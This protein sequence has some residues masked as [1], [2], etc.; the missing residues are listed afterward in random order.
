MTVSPP[1]FYA[2]AETVERTRTA[3]RVRLD[4][5]PGRELSW[6][7]GSPDGRNER[8]GRT[9][10]SVVTVEASGTDRLDLEARFRGG[11]REASWYRLALDSG[12]VPAS[13][14]VDLASSE[15][16]S[17]RVAGGERIDMRSEEG[18]ML[19]EVF[20]LGEFTQAGPREVF[21]LLNGLRDQPMSVGV[22]NVG[23]GNAN[24]LC[25]GGNVP[26]VYFDLG[27]GCAWNAAT[28][29]SRKAFC[30]TYDP[31]V[32]L[33]HWDFDHYF[34][35]TFLG[36]AWA[37]TWLVP[38]TPTVGPTPRAM[39]AKIVL[40]G[41]KVN[42][43]SHGPWSTTCGRVTLERP[44]PGSTSKNHSG[45]VMRVD[46]PGTTSARPWPVLLSGDMGYDYLPTSL[47]HDLGA[48]VAAHHG[49]SRYL[50]TPPPASQGP[51]VAYSFGSGNTYGHPK[52]EALDRHTA[53]GWH[54]RLDTMNGDIILAPQPSLRPVGCGGAQCGLFPVQ[55]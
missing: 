44:A 26:L 6:L 24:A 1:E 25:D 50:G 28:Y 5:L 35:G 36:A 23:Q 12:G 15:P 39:L 55:Q 42:V 17:V 18:R 51:T 2:H 43:W 3:V 13:M 52:P 20:S 54:R 10:A 27:G 45:I 33:S 47:T 31:M 29:V 22:Y 40:A 7:A 8:F 19:T 48:L 37:R 49:A 38:S 14:Y 41:G 9:R 32:I 30:W 11:L 21:N 34:S 4:L 16:Q 46:L 53:S